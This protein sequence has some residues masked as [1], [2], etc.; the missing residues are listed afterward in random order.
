ML[1]Q[2]ANYCKNKVSDFFFENMLQELRLKCF[3]RF[4]SLPL[5]VSVVASLLLVNFLQCIFNSGLRNDFPI[6]GGFLYRVETADVG[7]L[8]RV[9]ELIFI[10][11]KYIEAT[12]NFFHQQVTKFLKK[13]LAHRE[14]VGTNLIFKA[15]QNIHLLTLAL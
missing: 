12:K 1:F 15:L 3:P 9:T 11:R 8:K 6:T 2:R 5:V 14:K 7:S 13:T 10:I 4:S